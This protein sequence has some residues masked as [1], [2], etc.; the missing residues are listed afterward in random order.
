M[1]VEAPDVAVVAKAAPRLVFFLSFLSFSTCKSFGL[2]VYLIWA[3]RFSQSTDTDH[4]G[5][6]CIYLSLRPKNWP[7]VRRVK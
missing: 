4:A 7:R 3:G 5:F 6:T 2:L 1:R